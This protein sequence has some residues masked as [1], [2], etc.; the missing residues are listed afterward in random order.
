MKQKFL[1]RLQCKKVQCKN[2]K[3][4]KHGP[5]S[6]KVITFLRL[7]KFSNVDGKDKHLIISNSCHWG[8]GQGKDGHV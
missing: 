5:C 8:L 4:C 6:L 7:K 1:M 2:R 3:T